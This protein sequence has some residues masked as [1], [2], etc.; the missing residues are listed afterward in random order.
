[1]GY[2]DIGASAVL[3]LVLLFT[4]R[5]HNRSIIRYEGAALMVLYASYILWRTMILET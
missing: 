1:M 2:L 3:S 5:T 4:A